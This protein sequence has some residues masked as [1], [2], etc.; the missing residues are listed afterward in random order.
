MFSEALEQLAFR[1]SAF[2][3]DLNLDDPFDDEDFLSYCQQGM[4]EREGRRG[5]EPDYLSFDPSEPLPI[6]T[7]TYI[8][9]SSLNL[10]GG[11]M[12][13]VMPPIVELARA[14]NGSTRT[15]GAW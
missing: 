12:G 5:V 11:W 14:G 13:A 6:R 3:K 8:N 10:C 1:F 4:R 7:A 15:P 9:V 2:V